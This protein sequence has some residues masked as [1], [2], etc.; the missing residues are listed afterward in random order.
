MLTMSIRQSLLVAL[1]ALALS[2]CATLP[3]TPS[4]TATNTAD[5][6]TA[7]DATHTASVHLVGSQPGIPPLQ[8]LL[9][10]VQL[11]NHGSTPCW[12]LLPSNLP[13][14]PGGVDVIEQFEVTTGS[15]RVVV[16]RL[17]GTGGRYAMRLNPGAQVTL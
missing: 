12:V 14:S 15:N 16:G 7:S 4:A 1:L 17:L 9:V 3:S 2:G 11:A 8:R 10:D 5:S 6:D 13:M